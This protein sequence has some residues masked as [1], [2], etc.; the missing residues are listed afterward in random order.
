VRQSAIGSRQ[1]YGVGQLGA[2]LEAASQPIA[3]RRLPIA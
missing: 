3:D 2:V 1:S